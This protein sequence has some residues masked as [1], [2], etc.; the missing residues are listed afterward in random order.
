MYV[1]E[2]QLSD[3]NI[4][5]VENMDQQARKEY[6]LVVDSYIIE[7]CDNISEALRTL[8]WVYFSFNRTYP[9]NIACVLSFIQMKFFHIYATEGGRAKIKGKVQK[10]YTFINKL[11]NIDVLSML[12]TKKSKLEA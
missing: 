11:N 9:V 3:E 5:A 6:L 4:E 1:L 7:T 12:D 10:V 2:I 8:I